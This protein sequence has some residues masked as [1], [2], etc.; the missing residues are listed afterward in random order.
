LILAKPQ[1]YMNLS[2]TAVGALARFYKIPLDRLLVIYDDVDLP[3]GSLRLRP[4]GGSA[5]QKG[6]ASIIERFG[7]EDIPRLRVGIGRPSG[8]KAAEG[9]VL[10]D[11]NR[12]EL[13]DLD[14]ILDRAA[15]AALM[16]VTQG[17][18]MAMNEH[19]S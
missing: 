13:K 5:G 17:L 11:F 2:G 1:T 3:L 18:S 6:M 8:S 14:Q 12:A 4:S 7:T 10:Q 16:A 9:Y 15:D 19:N